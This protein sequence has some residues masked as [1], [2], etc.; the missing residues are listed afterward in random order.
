LNSRGLLGAQKGMCTTELV[1]KSDNW[2]SDISSY[3]IW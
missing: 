1:R 2:C 3:R